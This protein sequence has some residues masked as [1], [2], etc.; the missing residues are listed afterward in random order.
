MVWRVNGWFLVTV[1]RVRRVKNVCCLCWGMEWPV[2]VR[3]SE[4]RWVG[5]G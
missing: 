1:G 2:E 3:G 5:I 4:S